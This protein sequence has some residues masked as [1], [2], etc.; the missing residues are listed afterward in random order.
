M[1]RRSPQGGYVPD[2]VPVNARGRA[3][4]L[5]V[6]IIVAILGPFPAR[7]ASDL[8]ILMLGDSLT[9]GYGLPAAEALPARLEAA[10]RARGHAVSVINAGV[11]GDTT[12]GGR[13]RIGWSLASNPPPDAAIVALG[14]NDGLR[15]LEPAQM[16]E[17]LD[18]ILAALGKAGLPVLVAGMRAPRNFGSD[19]V[20]QYEAVFAALARK[21]GALFKPFLLDGVALDPALN[22]RDGIH[23]NEKGVAR[24]V[25][26]LLPLVEQLI[27]RAEKRKAG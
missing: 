14:A 21:H 4:A 18:A 12:A 11:S 20:R 19:Y 25:A 2:I 8:R 9:A 17:N 10:L 6:L 1:N 16:R 5:I 13:A 26:G 15:G 7:G 27:L 22:Q 3:L 23:P 24:I